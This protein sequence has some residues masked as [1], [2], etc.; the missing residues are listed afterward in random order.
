MSAPT[1]PPYLPLPDCVATLAVGQHHI[2]DDTSKQGLFTAFLSR[3][4]ENTHK[5]F[6]NPIIAYFAL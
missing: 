2:K 6:H 3:Q 5:K 1:T 4:K